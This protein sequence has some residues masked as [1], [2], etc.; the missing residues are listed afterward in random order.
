[1]FIHTYKETYSK[2]TVVA[3]SMPTST[4]KFQKM[5]DYCNDSFGPEGIRWKDEIRYG[6][7]RFLDEADVLQFVLAFS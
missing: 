4:V 7:V 6:E 3:F 5:V 1:M 2:Y